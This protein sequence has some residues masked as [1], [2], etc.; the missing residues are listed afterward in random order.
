MFVSKIALI[1]RMKNKNTLE[2]INCPSISLEWLLFLT[3]EEM[4]KNYTNQKV[5]LN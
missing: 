2:N 4:E 5:G 1:W 3:K